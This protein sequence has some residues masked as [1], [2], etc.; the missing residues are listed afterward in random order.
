MDLR[1]G[2]AGLVQWQGDCLPSS[3]YQFESDDPLRNKAMK[4]IITTRDGN[5]YT[6]QWK[7]GPKPRGYVSVLVDI[8]IEH[9]AVMR[10][11]RDECGG[12]LSVNQQIRDA[13]RG[14]LCGLVYTSLYIQ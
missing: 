10:Y 3:L 14:H 12:L 9:L 4:S 2:L 11:R 1:G 8:P 5:T 6:R 13:I 7:P